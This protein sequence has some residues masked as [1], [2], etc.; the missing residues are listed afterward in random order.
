MKKFFNVVKIISISLLVLALGAYVVLYIVNVDLAKEIMA[1]A[2]DY[3]NRPLPIVGVSVL[4]LAVLLWKIFSSSI[5]G[6]KYLNLAE[7]KF[8]EQ[9][10]ELKSEHQKEKEELNA[11][12][13][14]QDQEIDIVYQAALDVCKISP[15]KK[16]KEIGE[17]MVVKVES[18]KTQIRQKIDVVVNDN[19]KPL[20]LSKEE[21]VNE[22]IEKIKKELATYGEKGK[23]AIESIS[24]ATKI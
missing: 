18:A 23:E 3:L 14:L 8:E 24:E 7:Q 15:N 1:T 17:N 11:I 13:Q 22:V 21:I 12:I 6:K 5:Y 19:L 16:I 10:E 4:V 9:V 2:M 20:L